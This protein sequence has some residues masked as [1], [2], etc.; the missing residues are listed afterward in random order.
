[1]V[2]EYSSTKYTIHCSRFCTASFAV[3]WSESESTNGSYFPSPL[4]TFRQKSFDATDKLSSGDLKDLS[5][6]D[7]GRKGRAIPPAFQ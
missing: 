2:V 4:T 3:I 1:M 6:F 7:N 5:K